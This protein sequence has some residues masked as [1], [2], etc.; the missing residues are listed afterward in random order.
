MQ[1]APPR[2]NFAKKVRVLDTTLRDGEQTPGVSFSR[3]AKVA[4]AKRL[5][6]FGV[7]VIEAGSAING[8]AERKTM[9][10]VCEELGDNRMV[11]SFARIKEGDIEAVAESGAGSI[12]LVYPAS[13][14][15]IR[16]KLRCS[17]EEAVEKTARMAAYAKMKGLF[18]ELLA[19]DGSRAEPEFLMKTFLAAKNAGADAFCLCDTLGVL[20]PERTHELFEYLV[21]AG[22]V[23][24]HG[25]NDL[26]LAVA[27]TLAAL[28]AGAAGFHATVNGLGERTGNASLEEVC[29]N[30]QLHYGIAT[31]DLKQAYG[32][33][34]MVAGYSNFYPAQNKPLVGMGVFSHESGIHVDGLMKN[35]ELYEFVEPKLVGRER[36][37]TMG[38]LSG[39][40]SILYNLARFNIVMEDAKRDELLGMVKRM[41]EMGI[42]V[43]D[44]DFLILVDK[45]LGGETREKV[46]IEN[47][48]VTTGNKIPPTAS[49]QIRVGESETLKFGAS[50][51]DGPVD[52]AIKAVRDALA[53]NGVEL[54]SYH[55]DAITG[56]SDAGVRVN[57]R[58]RRDERQITS[59]AMGTDIVLVSVEAYRKALNVLL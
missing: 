11:A 30:L 20:T 3:E 19:E 38:K 59:S 2:N 4:I 8:K 10:K 56:G 43:S 23:S 12:C 39:R 24:F 50:I 6:D 44:A 13:D 49:V 17:R 34:R 58:V 46:A 57:I 25:H 32:L 21:G 16:E 55:V 26:G 52:A 7:D 22:S 41:G 51:G 9:E 42:K 33:S 28:R 54:V 15:H 14:L 45:V 37:I 1:F 18:V 5:K 27:N 29:A 53:E 31:V 47:I 48:V 36:E 35:P 40:K